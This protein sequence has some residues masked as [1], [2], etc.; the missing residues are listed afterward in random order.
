[1]KYKIV[2]SKVYFL[3]MKENPALNIAVKNNTSI[4]KIESEISTEEYRKLYLSVGENLNWL[5][6]IFMDDTQLYH[7][8]NSSKTHIYKFTID[9]QHAG[10]CE[11]I[12]CDKY[13]EILY[14]GLTPDFV[15]KGYGQYFLNKTI[16]LAWSYSPQWVQLNTCD[17]DHPNALSTY[18]RVGFEH[19]KTIE[20][21]KKTKSL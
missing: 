12:E 9:K 4:E 6:R 8:I 16:E 1:M 21:E 2:H 11:L 20:E 5:D 17:L 10:Y 18:K 14:F 7:K 3:K 13:V 15:G 19:Y